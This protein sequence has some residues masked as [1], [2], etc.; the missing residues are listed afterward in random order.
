MDFEH[1]VMGMFNT[2]TSIKGWICR[3]GTIGVKNG[4]PHSETQTRTL[5]V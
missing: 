2:G 3:T 4:R 1:G 5:I